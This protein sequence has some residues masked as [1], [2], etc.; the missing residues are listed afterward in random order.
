MTPIP[1][2][3]ERAVDR[4]VE[5]SRLTGAPARELRD[6]LEE[7]V[8]DALQAGGTPEEVRGRLGD[9]AGAGPLLARSARPRTRR[10]D[11]QAGESPVRA[12]LADLR[13]GLRTL[14]RAPGLALTAVLVL[15]V[16]M[17][18][19]TVGLTVV[20]EILL[21][22]LPVADQENLV[23]VWADVTRGNSFAGFGWRDYLAY[24]EVADAG[25]SGPLERLAA[26]AGTRL[27]LGEGT[28]GP[29]VVGQL[30][31]RE[32]LDMMGVRPTV[33][34]LEL[35]EDPA[36]GGP[37]QAVL[38]HALWA[39]RFGGDDGMVGRTVVLDGHPFT[40]VG[41]APAGFRGHFIGFPVDL[42]L[43]ITT[44]DLFLPGFDPDD[45]ARMPFE[46]IGRRAPG[47]TPEA[48]ERAMSMVSAGLETTHPDTHRGHGVGVTPTTG[49]DRSL[50]G[51]VA[52][53]VTVLTTLA[54]LVLVI[55]CLNVG[56]VLLVRTLSRE[57][58][59]GIRLALGAG[60][61]RLVRQVMAETLV[62]AGLGTAA[63][64]GLAFFL[65]GALASLFRNFTAGLGLELPLDGRVLTLTAVAGVAAALVAGGAPAL[66]LLRQPAASAL[67]AR[68]GTTGS[69]VRTVL[70]VGQ[71]AVSVALVV[72]AGLFLRAL[73]AG[74]R[75]DPGFD[76]DGVATFVVET[77]PMETDTP[78]TP[79]MDALSALPGIT[80]ATVAD[81]G[82][83]GVARTPFRFTLP[84]VTPPPEEDSWAVDGRRVGAR[85]LATLG[86]PL[87]SGRDFTAADAREGPAVGV[88]SEAFARRFWPDEDAVGRSF[89]A[90]GE[91]IRVVG[92]AADIRYL[93]QDETP[94]PFVYLSLAGRRPTVAHLTLRASSPE[95]V[96]GEVRDLLARLRPGARPPVLTTPREVL[97]RALLPQRLGAVLVGAMGLMA[98]LLAAVGLYGLV[99]YMVSRDRHELAVR[100]ALGGS[101]GAL[102]GAVLRKGALLVAAGTALGLGLAAVTA[103]ALGGFLAGVSP[104]DPLT[105]ASV[106]LL[107]GAVA[108]AASWLP[109]RRA[110]RIQPG[111]ALRRE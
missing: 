70:V 47:A 35:P 51:V 80:A 39:E 24:R 65:N 72:A 1:P 97:D 69:R 99:Q 45:R 82:P 107:F 21:R 60:N 85:Y 94:D 96:T 86:I 77:S 50:R 106:A 33:G 98:L 29:T 62:L 105:Y 57:R 63:G 75:I 42:W 61:G 7:H 36:F 18:T 48:V 30:V 44:A 87:R 17:A 92:V 64:L 95:A 23:D 26:F 68:K 12:F 13:Y 54:L 102:L 6:D 104:I 40:V 58:E 15:G 11:P 49:V 83:T 46:M 19:T 3:L 93:V 22:P 74:G 59:M 43:P 28:D 81:A 2:E 38:S 8:R 56:G 100:L 31:S 53:F 89:Q 71:V 16:G 32:Y 10:P 111:A 91:T 27:T 79:L 37:T 88:V 84:G 109:A 52:A 108:L 9:P 20:N 76:A 103:P 25:G 14:G 73:A 4:L 78:E 101:G 41:V 55:A 90:G 66:H 110:A 67:R 34:T 5:A